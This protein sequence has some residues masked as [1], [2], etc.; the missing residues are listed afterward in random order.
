LLRLVGMI[1]PAQ[2]APRPGAPV[3]PNVMRQQEFGGDGG[4]G[5]GAP[6]GRIPRRIRRPSASGLP[7]W[8]RRR[9]AG[10]IWLLAAGAWAVAR[11]VW[12]SVA[13][14]IRLS[15][16]GRIWGAAAATASAPH[17]VRFWTFL[18]EGPG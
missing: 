12:R 4:G 7:G 13:G 17:P 3:N 1:D 2:S 9:P 11:R 16:T 8:V 10:W 18:N 15:T 5:S 6:A 14:R